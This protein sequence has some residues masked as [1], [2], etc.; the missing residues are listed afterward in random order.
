MSEAPD[1][2]DNPFWYFS[3]A[4]YG[5]PGIA[6]HLL[7]FQDRCDADVN[8]M[9]FCCWTAHQGAGPLT[10]AR[11][12]ELARAMSDWQSG[13]I[14]PLRALR[15]ILKDDSQGAPPVLSSHVRETIKQAELDAERVEQNM[16]NSQASVPAR[17]NPDS[18]AI[19]VNARINMATYLRSLGIEPSVDDVK[20][21]DDIVDALAAIS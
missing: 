1:W 12:Q 10:D 20:I 14:K 17:G 2:P 3:L 11:V 7:Y 21:L 8:L 13:I 16:L 18:L 6:D 5:M 4:L 9:L 15:R 19:Q